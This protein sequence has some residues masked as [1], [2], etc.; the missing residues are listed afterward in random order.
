MR[1]RMP[2]G[3]RAAFVAVLAFLTFAPAATAAVD[4]VNTKKLRQNVTVNGILQH[5]RQLQR[6]ANMNGGTRASG[7]AGYDASV[8]YVK[9]RMKKAGYKVSEQTFDFPFFQETAAPA[10]SVVSPDPETFTTATFEYSGSGDVTAK[11]QAVDVIVPIDPTSDPS[12]SNSGCEASDFAG[13]VAGN[14]ALMQ[15]GTCDFAVKAANAEAAG[16][17]G[18]IIFNEGQPGRTD[19]IAGTLGGPDFSIPVVGLSYADGAELV[20]ETRPGRGLPSST[21]RRSRRS[22]PPAT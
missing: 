4:E 15:R 22:V 19:V 12:T 8:A 5:E 6:I 13:F 14:V 20:E 21:S 9:D 16:A 17:S 3:A 18:A 10:L 2:F 7:T 1:F 11:A